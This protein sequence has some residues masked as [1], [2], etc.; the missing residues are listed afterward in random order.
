MIEKLVLIVICL[1]I[2]RAQNH[3]LLR[4]VRQILVVDIQFDRQIDI[5]IYFDRQIDRE[6]YVYMYTYRWIDRHLDRSL[7]KTL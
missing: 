3:L 2:I 5:D 7:L 4:L 6:T 1:K